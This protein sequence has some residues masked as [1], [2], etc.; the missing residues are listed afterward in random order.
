MTYLRTYARVLLPVVA[1]MLALS[2]TSPALAAPPKFGVVPGVGIGP[3]SVGD[4]RAELAASLGK[5]EQEGSV[6]AYT[7]R[8]K[9]REGVV[10]VLFDGQ[11]AENVF[12]VDPAFVYR[13]VRVGDDSDEAISTLRGN[14]FLSGRCGPARALY[15]PDERTMF[16][17]YRGEVEHIFVV[18]DSGAC[19]A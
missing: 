4:T 10:K 6:W 19:G 13:G 2:V 3:V 12:T 9:G 16:G 14:G 5:P 17:L 8:A 18:R 15:T 11:R 1:L 7:V